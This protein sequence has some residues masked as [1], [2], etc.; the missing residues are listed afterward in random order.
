MLELQ[1]SDE[2]CLER[3]LARA[4]AEGRVDDS[5][6]VIARRLAIY[7][8]ET[9]PLVAYYLPTGNVVGIHGEGAIDGVW[10]EIQGALERVER[11][12]AAGGRVIVLKSPA[13]IE[14]MAEAGQ[15]VS[16]TLA[17]IGEAVRPGV[18]TA[19]LDVAADEF[20]RSQGGIP[21]FMGY[22]G[23]PASTCFSPNAMVVHGIPGDYRLEEGDILSADVGVTLGGFVADSRVHLRVGEI[24]PEAE[25]LLEACAEALDAG[26]ERCRLGQP[27]L[28]HLERRADGRRGGG[29]HRHPRA[30]RARRRA[31]DARGPSDPELRPAGPRPSLAE[32]MTF[33]IEP[34]ISAGRPEIYV[35]DDRWSI[36]T[37]DGSLA[38]HF[39]HTVAVTASGPRILTAAPVL[40]R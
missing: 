37:R 39:E 18:T 22:R 9:A 35:H 23:Y 15:I 11:A 6:E 29:L 27:P 30:S 10:A 21:T 3:L 12:P 33:A 40:L 34:M 8:E 20:I 19:E 14:Q 36:S 24:S 17:L 5:P 25:R 38:A 26:I 31:L 4:G 32:G 1:V 7:H 13:E 28:R 16:D 2:L